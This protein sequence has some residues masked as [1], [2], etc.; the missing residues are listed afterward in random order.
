MW[1]C[2]PSETNI[3]MSHGTDA[4]REAWGQA[5]QWGEKEKKNRRRLVWGGG[6]APHFLPPQATVRLPSLLDIFQFY[7]V[8][9]LFPLLRSLRSLATL[10]VASQGFS[11]PSLKTFAAVLL[12]PT[13][14]HWISEDGI[15]AKHLFLTK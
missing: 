9:C 12:H 7:P 1:M 15:I 14:R 4:L 3:G 10:R 13:D 2:A 8:F 5:S 11:R 6:K